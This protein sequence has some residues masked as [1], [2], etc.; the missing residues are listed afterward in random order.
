MSDRHDALG[1]IFFF[2]NN[3]VWCTARKQR[4]TFCCSARDCNR[5]RTKALGNLDGS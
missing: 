4:I 2:T 1:D 5:Q 3:D